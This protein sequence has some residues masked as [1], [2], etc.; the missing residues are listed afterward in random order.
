LLG[1]SEKHIDD[2]GVAATAR[3]HGLVS[4][5][6]NLADVAARGVAALDP[7]R[8]SPRVQP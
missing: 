3:I 2:T 8:P 4:V 1:E 6:R 7:Y 5:T